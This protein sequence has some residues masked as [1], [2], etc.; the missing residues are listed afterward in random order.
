MTMTLTAVE[1]GRTRVKHQYL[2]SINIIKIPFSVPDFQFCCKGI[3]IKRTIDFECKLKV[4]P[5]DKGSVHNFGVPQ[6]LDRGTPANHGQH[7][8]R[9]S[10]NRGHYSQHKDVTL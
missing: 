3:L 5:V 10:G 7:Q 1:H 8:V 2:P 9:S 4:Q 6:S